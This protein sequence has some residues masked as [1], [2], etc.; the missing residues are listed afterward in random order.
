MWKLRED[1]VDEPYYETVG[2]GNKSKDKKGGDNRRA[3]TW[4]HARKEC[5]RRNLL[6]ENAVGKVDQR[7]EGSTL[8]LY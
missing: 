7:E 8:Y 4:V 1:Q 3:I 5:H 6:F 2:D